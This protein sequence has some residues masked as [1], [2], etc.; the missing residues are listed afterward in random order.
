MVELSEIPVRLKTYILIGFVGFQPTNCVEQLFSEFRLGMTM[1]G[2]LYSS[3]NIAEHSARF[4]VDRI[5]GTSLSF[6]LYFL[7]T[8]HA[9]VCNSPHIRRSKS[10]T[11]T[12]NSQTLNFMHTLYANVEGPDTDYAMHA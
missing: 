1:I 10:C 6:S 2:M 11:C 3:H 5:R 7:L 4:Y 9:F 8:I 12:M